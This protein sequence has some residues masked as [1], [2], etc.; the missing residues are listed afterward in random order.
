[1]AKTRRAQVGNLS[2]RKGADF[3]REVAALIGKHL[4]VAVRRNLSQYQRSGQSY[5]YGLSGWSIAC[6]HAK[7]DSYRPVLVF[8]VDRGPVKCVLRLCDVSGRLSGNDAP[9]LI[10]FG[11]WC[12]IATTNATQKVA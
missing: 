3:E 9:V 5:L 4:G 2:H 7:T 8:R 11:T 12:T 6:A 10:D 1:M